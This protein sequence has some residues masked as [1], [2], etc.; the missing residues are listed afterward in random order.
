MTISSTASFEIGKEATHPE[1]FASPGA[2]QW[3]AIAR[4]LAGSTPDNDNAARGKTA[5]AVAGSV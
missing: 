5:F 2:A 1:T 4:F 3:L